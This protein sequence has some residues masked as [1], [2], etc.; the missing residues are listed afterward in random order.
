MTTTQP[1]TPPSPTQAPHPLDP[2]SPNEIRAAARIIRAAQPLGESAR[3]VTIELREPPKAAL[4]SAGNGA[5]PRQAFAILLDRDSNTTHEALVNL[6]AGTLTS[7]TEQPG[8]QPYFLFEE[9]ADAVTLT[10]NHPAWRAAVARRGADPDAVHIEPQPAGLY[11]NAQEEGTRLMRV[12]AYGQPNKTDAPWA[13]PIEGLICLVDIHKREVVRL[14]D[15]DLAPIPQGNGNYDLAAV[16]PLRTDL[17]PLDIVQPQGV[18]FTLTGHQLAWQ[19]WRMRVGFTPREGLVLYQIAY[20]DPHRDGGTLRPICHRAS[21]GELVVPYGATGP[22]QYWRNFFDSGEAGIGRFANALELGCDCLGEITYLDAVWT[23]HNGEP[24]TVPN[25]I[26]IHEEDVGVL[27]KHNDIFQDGNGSAVRRSRRLVVSYFATVGNYDYG[28]YWYF[29]EDGSIEVDIKLTG[30]VLTEAVPDETATN[31]PTLQ[32][33]TLVDTNLAAPNHQ[34]LFCFRLDMDV[35]GPANTVYEMHSEPLP[36]GPQNPHG[37]AFRSV[38]TPLTSEQNAIRDV[39][40]ASARYWKIVNPGRTNAAGHPT[41]YALIPGETVPMMAAPDSS[42]GRRAGFAR[43]Q[44]WVTPNAEDERYPAG[45]YPNLHPGGDGLPRWTTADRPLENQDLVL[46]YTVGVNHIVRPE[47]W[48]VSPVHRA[49]FA[50][51]PWAFFDR[52]PALDVAPPTHCH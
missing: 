25:A 22:G 6:T 48:P 32:T 24:T 47:E 35:D 7:W 52:N 14:V 15:E 5:L 10:R 21:L 31:S 1:A 8:V 41:A 28:F 3:F 42:P 29:Y 34:H 30:V 40:P 43:H 27:W 37:N 9:F 18:S 23:D 39:D 33:S 26:C 2:L 16:G 20:D 4:T 44:L 12:L 51:K 49:G 11:D 13:Q 19:R 36:A 17:K 45:D 50:L 46:W 38:A